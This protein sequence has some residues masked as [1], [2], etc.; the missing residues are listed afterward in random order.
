[1]RGGRLNRTARAAGS[2]APLLAALLVALPVPAAA[3]GNPKVGP[4][5]GSSTGSPPAKVS[6]KVLGG[7]LG[8][9]NT[10]HLSFRCRRR[11]AISGNPPA[12]DGTLRVQGGAFGGKLVHATPTKRFVARL[13]GELLQG[14]QARGWLR[15]VVRFP[16]DLCRTV[17][18]TVEWTA[19]NRDLQFAS[20]F[21]PPVSVSP[22]VENGAWHFPIT[23]DDRG[24]DWHSDLPGTGWNAFGTLV[25]SD[26]PIDDYVRTDT[27]PVIGPNGSRTNALFQEVLQNAEFSPGRRARSQFIIRQLR[28]RGSV[29]YWIKLQPNLK[30]VMPEGHVAWR[31]LEELRGNMPGEP[32]DYRMSIGLLRRP[33]G[34]IQWEVAARQLRPTYRKDFTLLATKPAVPIGKWFRLTTS[35]LI[36]RHHGYLRVQ[37]NGNT[38]AD[39]EGRTQRNVPIN[40]FQIFK[41]YASDSTL[42]R[43]PAYQWIDD[44]EIRRGRLSP[45]PVEAP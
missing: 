41:A 1:M 10:S 11:P 13:G 39:H 28:R 7:R 20:S 44:V 34:P 31:F 23:G 40:S 32:T 24:F 9:L 29:S 6:F 5:A 26:Q 33:T 21:E 19:Q 25:P 38:I 22:V 37:V 16:K 18:A 27:R 4:Y 42:A 43:G 30:K 17:P 8:D 3:T 15:Y 2:R 12:L 36:S 45:P 35:W 14:G